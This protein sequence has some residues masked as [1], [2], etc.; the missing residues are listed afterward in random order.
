MKNIE[1]EFNLCIFFVVISH[2]LHIFVLITVP[3]RFEFFYQ[4]VNLKFHSINWTFDC[5]LNDISF[6]L[7]VAIFPLNFPEYQKSYS[8]WYMAPT[9][10]IAMMTT[11]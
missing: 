3:I 1:S 6:N 7:L 9:T 2:L 5:L 10:A 8:L 4:F 11:R